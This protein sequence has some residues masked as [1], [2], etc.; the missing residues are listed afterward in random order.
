MGKWL[1]SFLPVMGKKNVGG[2]S[3]NAPVSL[4]AHE[5]DEQPVVLALCADYVLRVW[6]VQVK[7]DVAVGGE[8]LVVVG[9][10]VMG[11]VGDTRLKVLPL[12][13]FF[14]L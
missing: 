14:I 13:L 8:V 4:L 10:N 2:A 9:G 7:G 11:G 5:F 1:S 6:S 12:V 3:D